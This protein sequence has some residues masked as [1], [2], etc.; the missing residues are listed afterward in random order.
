VQWK[1]VEA[2]VA[3]SRKGDFEALVAVLDPNVV[4]RADGG[5]TGLSHHVRG[6]AAVARQAT[7]FG[8]AG[9]SVRRVLVN[10][11][12]GMLAERAG[13][14]FSVGAFTVRNAKIVECD[15]LVDPERVAQLNLKVLED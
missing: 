8:Q 10:G 11:A 15:F 14:V 9:F 4:L 13:K 6:A 1:V 7:I 3:A 2:F 5:L 12:A